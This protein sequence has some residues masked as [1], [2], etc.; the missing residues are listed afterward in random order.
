VLLAAQLGKRITARVVASN[1]SGN[2][3]S[4][5]APTTAVA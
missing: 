5:T 1:A 4:T 3:I 2:G